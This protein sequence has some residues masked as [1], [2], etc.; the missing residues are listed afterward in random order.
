MEE[1]KKML[2]I[3]TRVSEQH[4]PSLNFIA[5]QEMIAPRVAVK[6]Y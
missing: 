2:S 5:R 4:W 3:L 1:K 6:Q